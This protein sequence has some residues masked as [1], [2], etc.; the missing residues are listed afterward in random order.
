VR[1]TG[2]ERQKVKVHVEEGLQ[3]AAT[4]FDTI[5]LF[6]PNGVDVL[7]EGIPIADTVKIA[8]EGAFGRR[9]V[10]IPVLRVKPD[11][12][13]GTLPPPQQLEPAGFYEAEN[14]GHL[15]GAELPDPEA[16]G[17]TAWSAVPGKAQPGHIV[18]GPY[19]GM[20]AGRYLV[21]FRIK[22]TDEAQGAL[23]KVDTC[24]G[25]GS[26]ITAERIVQAQELPLGA[27]RY[28]ALTTSHPGG[29]IETRV[30]WFGTAG[31]VVDHVGIWRIR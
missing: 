6:P 23:L 14:L 5:D 10:R 22:R 11:M 24:V 18:F 17:G 26:P 9:E 16:T 13:V 4:S 8:F 1:N 12:V 25:G 21:L 15:S 31:V 3:Q 29:A 2:K 19:A 27:Y 7:V 20:P 30:E 28:V